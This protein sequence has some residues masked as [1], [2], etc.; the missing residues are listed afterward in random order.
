V[1]LAGR[2]VQYKARWQGKV[3][4]KRL[5]KWVRLHIVFFVESHVIGMAVFP[6]LSGC[7]VGEEVVVIHDFQ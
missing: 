2:V 3:A 5:V 7:R 1:H 4:R 6:R